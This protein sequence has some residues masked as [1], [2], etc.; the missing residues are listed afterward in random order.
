MK[1]YINQVAD[2]DEP[3][4]WAEAERS[5]ALFQKYAP[6][7]I[8]SL[9]SPIKCH[10]CGTEIGY[11]RPPLPPTGHWTH[12]HHQWDRGLGVTRCVPKTELSSLDEPGRA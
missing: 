11:Q 7:A 3:S 2:L 8:V 10:S 12:M 4:D 5:L 6:G 1:L 9:D